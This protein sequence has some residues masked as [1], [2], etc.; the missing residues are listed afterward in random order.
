[1]VRQSTRA[2]PV[3][4]LLASMCFCLVRSL[5]K[6]K[7]ANSFESRPENVLATFPSEPCGDSVLIQWTP[8][9]QDFLIQSY[10]VLCE[11]DNLEDRISKIVEDGIYKTVMGPLKSGVTYS[12]SVAARTKLHGTGQP[13]FADP[14]LT[15]TYVLFFLHCLLIKTFLKTTFVVDLFFQH[16]NAVAV[17]QNCLYF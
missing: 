14:F 11:T 9:S 12:C 17:E 5:N 16:R 3:L 13:S 6:G 2:S 4:V 1:M 10:L 15:E 8:P 7:L